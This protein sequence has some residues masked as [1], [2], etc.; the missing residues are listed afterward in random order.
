M[1][2]TPHVESLARPVQCSPLPQGRKP[3]PAAMVTSLTPDP[4]VLSSSCLP[5][6]P[7]YLP[8]GGISTLH[9]AL[10][11]CARPAL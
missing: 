6:V 8:L 3:H 5:P 7:L 10:L 4:F 9:V 1:R 2:R 11:G